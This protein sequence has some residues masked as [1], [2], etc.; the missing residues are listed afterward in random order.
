[1]NPADSPL[2][3]TV[4]VSARASGPTQSVWLRIFARCMAG[5][6]MAAGA[7]ALVA[8]ITSGAEAA[9]SALF[10][11]VL[12]AFFFGI[13]LLIGHFVGRNNPSGA[14]GIFAVTY[15][16]KVVGFAAILF[17][18]GVPE[19]LHRTWFFGA[20]VGTVVLWQTVEVM[21]FARSRHQLYGDE[22]L[23]T[24]NSGGKESNE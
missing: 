1:M 11:W 12:V 15:A 13:S 7:A 6:G 22:P 2:P 5:T 9:G 4:G 20:A 10:G 21:V 24:E 8:L 3:G 16:I 23:A 17:M 19:W 18:L 14:L